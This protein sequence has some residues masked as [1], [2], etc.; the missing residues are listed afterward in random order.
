MNDDQE[1]Q[2]CINA[3]EN[4]QQLKRI[5]IVKLIRVLRQGNH[6]TSI[7]INCDVVILLSLTQTLN[8]QIHNYF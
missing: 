2:F 1:P 8:S 4:S 6:S 7:S 5:N 3:W